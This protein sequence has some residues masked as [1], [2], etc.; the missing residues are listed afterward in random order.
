[1]E[2]KRRRVT[3][4]CDRCR[5]LKTKCDGVQPVCSRCNAYGY[6][7]S[8]EKGGRRGFTHG[9]P[10]ASPPGT[11][12]LSDITTL[13][14]AIKAYDEL[15]LDIRSKASE[16]DR[17]RLDVSLARIRMNLPHEILERS[18]E[19]SE[20]DG[21]SGETPQSQVREHQSPYQRY[22]GEASDVYFFNSVK[23]L[24][25][26]GPRVQPEKLDSYERDESTLKDLSERFPPHLPSRDE[27]DRCIEIY[28]STI[29]V[30]YPFICQ[31]EFR[32]EYVKFWEYTSAKDVCT[33]WFATFCKTALA[34]LLSFFL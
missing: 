8:W 28:F 1:M 3:R 15:L 13:R 4:A 16:G 14:Q 23:D 5:T 34:S 29:H 33:T 24:L 12:S 11:S 2:L 17:T 25:R 10:A 30:A 19:H 32:R 26:H 31:Q 7:C 6:H 9:D 20:S 22:L 18:Q 27:A 21:A